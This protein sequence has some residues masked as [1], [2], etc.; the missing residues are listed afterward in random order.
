M[1]KLLLAILLCLIIVMA[2]V[3]ALPWLAGPG[4]RLGLRVAGF[5]DVGLHGR[6]SLMDRPPRDRVG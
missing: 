2:A 3:T 5:E 6:G 4:L 1:R